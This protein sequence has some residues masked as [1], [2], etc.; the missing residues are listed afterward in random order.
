M[1]TM[2]ITDEDA[3]DCGIDELEEAC[4]LG[5]HTSNNA[6]D[7]GP[8]YIL[9]IESKNGEMVSKFL[10]DLN[11][12]DGDLLLVF[13]CREHALAAIEEVPTGYKNHESYIVYSQQSILAEGRR[14]LEKYYNG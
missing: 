7:T 1:N 10:M 12:G 6:T 4:G 3:W 2:V 5:E 14:A 11:D 9:M 8:F 13:E